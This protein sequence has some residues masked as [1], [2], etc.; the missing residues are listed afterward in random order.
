M[1][2]KAIKCTG[3]AAPVKINGGGH[4]IRTLNC[5]YCGTVMDVQHDYRRL[6]KFVNQ[7]KPDSP[8]Q[9]GMEGKIKDIPFIIIGMIGYRSNYGDTWVD[10]FLFS[11]TH[12]YAHLTYSMGHFVFTRRVRYL[13]DKKIQQLERRATFHVDNRKY[14]FF[15]TYQSEITYVAGE[16]TW[17][18]KKSDTCVVRDAIA[19]P[20]MFTQEICNNENETEYYLSEYLDPKT[21]HTNFNTTYQTQ[22]SKHFK[23]PAQPFSAPI[24]QAI[25][26]ASRI[27]LITATLLFVLMTLFGIGNGKNIYHKTLVVS[28]ANQDILTQNITINNSKHLIELSYKSTLNNAWADYDIALFKDN[29][30]VFSFKKQLATSS[31]RSIEKG[32]L[33]NT[34]SGIARFKVK[35]AGNYSLRIIAT[36]NSTK[37]NLASIQRLT[38]NIKEGVMGKKYMIILFII[39]LISYAWFY[40]AR[41]A[42]EKKRWEDD[43]D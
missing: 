35:K 42:F 7:N 17:I 34:R 5:N 36:P 19:P 4:R 37:N 32:L 20:F 38:I 39:G 25:S 12:G 15:E 6:G 21:I 29:I 31:G 16:L 24:K 22:R 9:I 28:E 1:N 23:H 26:K 13:P 30:E 40:A 2:A 27:A 3:C 33:K 14:A 8:L 18:A 43:D 41:Y 10:L 11:D